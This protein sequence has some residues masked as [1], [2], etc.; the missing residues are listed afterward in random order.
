MKDLGELLYTPTEIEMFIAKLAIKLNK[1]YKK[2][3][4]V[5]VGVLNGSFYFVADL[6]RKL[7][8][9]HEVGFVDAKSYKDNVSTGAVEIKR[10][11]VSIE[12]RNVLIIEDIIDTGTTIKYLKETFLG[13]KAK[14]VKVCTLL[15]RC[16]TFKADYI[17]TEVETK[18]FLVGYGLDLDN[19]FRNL[20][21]IMACGGS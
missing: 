15:N 3:V 20:P 7:T 9:V 11:N 12:G 10:L 19:Q 6:T 13:W 5:L 14:E 8:F 17:G 16:T 18:K 1:D 4:P 2:S 21:Y